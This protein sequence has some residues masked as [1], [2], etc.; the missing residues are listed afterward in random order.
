MLLLHPHNKAGIIIEWE[1]L[2]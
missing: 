2:C 1:P